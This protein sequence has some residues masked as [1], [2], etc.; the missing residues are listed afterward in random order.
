MIFKTLGYLEDCGILMSMTSVYITTLLTS[1]SSSSSSVIGPGSKLIFC[2]YANF[3]FG[4]WACKAVIRTF[5]SNWCST[6]VS[7]VIRKIHQ[8]RIMHQ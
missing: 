5:C 4:I 1:Q 6:S 2:V 3:K 8:W 7:K